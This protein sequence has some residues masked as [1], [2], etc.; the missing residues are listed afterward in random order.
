MFHCASDVREMV[1]DSSAASTE[2]HLSR[3]VSNTCKMLQEK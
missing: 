2:A 1:N 3:N